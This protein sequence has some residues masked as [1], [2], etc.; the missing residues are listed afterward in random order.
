MDCVMVWRA[1]GLFVPNHF[2][3]VTEA[4]RNWQANRSQLLTGNT[5]LVMLPNKDAPAVKIEREG[6]WTIIVQREF[7]SMRNTSWKSALAQ[8]EI[9]LQRQIVPLAHIIF[10][11]PDW[12]TDLDE[13]FLPQHMSIVNSEELRLN[14]DHYVQQVFKQYTSTS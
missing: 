2:Q 3:E 1:S 13:G 10:A 8:L 7:I 6:N 11:K 14:T 4:H 12:L 9:A 5:E